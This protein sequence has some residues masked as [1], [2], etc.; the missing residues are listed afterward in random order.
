MQLN[1]LVIEFG[2]IIQQFIPEKNANNY[3]L[4]NNNNNNI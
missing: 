4:Q 2:G 3:Y 1:K